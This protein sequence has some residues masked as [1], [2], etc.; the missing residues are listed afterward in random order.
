MNKIKWTFIDTYKRRRVFNN[1]VIS[2][3]DA[4]RRAWQVWRGQ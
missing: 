1:P 2:A 4:I 3:I